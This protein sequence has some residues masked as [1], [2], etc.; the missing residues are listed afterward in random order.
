MGFDKV[1]NVS[2]T[3]IIAGSRNHCYSGKPT[4]LS[5][6][7]LEPHVTGNNTGTSNIVRRCLY[8]EFISP[9]DN[10]TH[11]YSCRFPAI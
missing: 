4:I 5:L 10:K 7:I 9:G 3:N 2:R 8:K 11:V 6:C 1:N